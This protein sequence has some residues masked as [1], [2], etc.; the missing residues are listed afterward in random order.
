MVHQGI[1]SEVLIIVGA[2]PKRKKGVLLL[3][4]PS[5]FEHQCPPPWRT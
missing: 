5:D 1:T 2:R 4:Q 3:L